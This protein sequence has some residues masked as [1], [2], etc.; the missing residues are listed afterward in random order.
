MRTLT[1]VSVVA[2]AVLVGSAQQSNSVARLSGADYAEIKNAYGRSLHAVSTGNGTSF[3]QSFTADGEM[4][5]SDGTQSGR[6]SLTRYGSAQRGVRHWITNLAIEALPDG[7]LSWAYVLDSRGQDFTFGALYRDRWVRTSD[8]WRIRKRE[9]FPGNKMP[10]RDHYAAPSNVGDSTFTPR[11]Y[12]E[13]EH[14]LT[15]YNLG[16]DNAGI[17]DKGQLASLSFTRDAVFERPG[18]P[19]RKGREG[20]IAQTTEGQTKGGLHHWD[21][22]LLMDVNPAGHIATFGYDVLI[23]VGESGSPVRVNSTGT[24]QHRVIRS[25]EGWL[26]NYRIYEGLSAVPKISWPSPTFRVEASDFTRGADTAAY[27]RRGRLTSVD[28]V[29]IEQLYVRNNIAFDSA[30]EHGAAFARTFTS[31]GSWTRGG[32]TTTGTLALTALAAANTRG[33]ETWTSNLTLEPTKDGATGRVYVLM[34]DSQ[35]TSVAVADLGTFIDVLVKTRDGWRFKKRTYVSEPAPAG[36]SAG[37]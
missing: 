11:D 9:V 4:T 35:H 1:S 12:Y 7:A 23:N 24:L 25:D 17:F 30:G 18:G 10:P 16:Y 34:K 15:R 36:T 5:G 31:D 21:G 8:G 13:I 27:A 37:R 2:V 14:L 6:P 26:I 22:N 32:V 28:D 33:L 3:A 29:E 19:T 20:V